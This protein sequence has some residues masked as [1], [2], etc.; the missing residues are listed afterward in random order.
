MKANVNYYDIL[1]ITEDEKKLQGKDFEKV[2]KKKFKTIALL[3]HPDRNGNKSDEEKKKLEE[4]FKLASE[5]YDTLLN[6][7]QEYDNPSS[8][9]NFDGFSGGFGDFMNGFEFDFNPFGK[10]KRV[11][12]GQTIR[13]TLNVSLEDIYN[14][15]EKTI[16]YNRM[17]K[18]PT[19]GG[20]GKGHNSRIETCSHC[21]GTGKLFQRN[22]FVQ[23][24]TTCPYCKGKGTILINPCQTCNGQGIV[25][26]ENTVTINI[27]KGIMNGIQMN[28]QGQ[29]SAPV[30]CDGIYGDL[31]MVINEAPNKEFERNGN[32]LYVN[33]EIPVIDGILGCSTEI[34]TIDGKKLST[35][36]SQGTEDG[37]QIRFN[38]K[39]MPIMNS[40]RF[41]NMIGIIKLKMP[42]QLT[43]DELTIL[44]ELKTK[45]NFQ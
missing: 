6:R 9:F 40:N 33:I 32:D 27:P 38:G 39:G 16:K 21:G 25:P 13:I 34:K 1:G 18:C 23:T 20:S 17:D 15:V 31:L 10:Q 43:N 42:K 3:K 28:M 22:G 35:K 45:Q 7:R 4:E 12:K 14:G 30:N 29:G 24:I 11:N 5:A 2:L 36:I 37:T 26:T 8:N 41:G 19:C 44:E